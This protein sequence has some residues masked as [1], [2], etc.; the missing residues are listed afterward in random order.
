M[1]KKTSRL[2]T[3]SFPPFDSF[4][5]SN[6]LNNFEDSKQ[7]KQQLIDSIELIDKSY[8]KD[9]DNQI[10][11]IIEI[12]NDSII[13]VMISIGNHYHRLG[14]QL[15]EELNSRKLE[16]S[17]MTKNLTEINQQLV[18]SR[19]KIDGLISKLKKVERKM[20]L[21]DQ[22]FNLKT[23]H[24]AHYKE[25]FNYVMKDELK[26][27]KSRITAAMKPKPFVLNDSKFQLSQ[28][29][30]QQPQQSSSSFSQKTPQLQQFPS[31]LARIDSE[32]E[33]RSGSGAGS[34]SISPTPKKLR[35]YLSIESEIAELKR[36]RST[37]IP[38]FTNPVK[39]ITSEAPTCF[40]S[41]Q[42]V[43]VSHSVTSP[44]TF[45]PTIAS[46]AVSGTTAIDV[47]AVATSTTPTTFET[48]S[49]SKKSPSTINSF[50]HFSRKSS[51]TGGASGSL[52]SS[53]FINDL[54]KL[55]LQKSK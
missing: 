6:I 32:P 47:S 27:K 20:S 14:K 54:K 49:L 35:Q 5:L 41:D 17:K 53:D 21:K 11:L 22:L 51:T 39:H 15:Q 37:S 19:G 31:A 50:G 40:I 10:K 25:L 8:V 18:Q 38:K 34:G 26:A 13:S 44:T 28:P 4:K 33:S 45:T 55:Q 1:K 2:E 52:K 29:Q 48:F 43:T 16:I 30:Q 23:P 36:Q 12:E 42:N 7:I 46:T 9:I 3:Y 24:E